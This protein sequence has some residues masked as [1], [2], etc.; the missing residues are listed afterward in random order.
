MGHFF[1]SEKRVKEKVIF[2]ITLKEQLFIK[3][4]HLCDLYDLGE[5]CVE[6]HKKHNN[7]SIDCKLKL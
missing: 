2:I 7:L 5:N 3:V 6:E 4:G 1:F